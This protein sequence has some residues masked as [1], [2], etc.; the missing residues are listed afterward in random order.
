MYK[1]QGVSV[2]LAD[3][4]D[5]FSPVVLNDQDQFHRAEVVRL[6]QELKQTKNTYAL[7]KS[8]LKSAVYR[9]KGYTLLGGQ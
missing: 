5:P 1:R 2:S 7:V 8:I 6:G 4:N 3:I 9:Q